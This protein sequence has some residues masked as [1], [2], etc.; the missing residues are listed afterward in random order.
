MKCSGLYTALVTPFKAGKLDEA[1]LKK[2]IARQIE[3]GVNKMVLLG[4]TGE[5]PTLSYE[6]KKSIL[7][8]GRQEIGLGTMIV[9]VGTPSTTT[10]IELAKIAEDFG[11]D[12]L[13]GVTPYYNKPNQEGI[14]RHFEEVS[15]H[16]SLP[17]I[18]YSVKGRTGV[19]IDVSTV[20]RLSE[21]P[22]IVG[23]KE[24]SCDLSQITDIIREMRELRKDFAILSGD[25]YLTFPIM[26]L[27]GHGLIGS[28]VSNVF[29][30]KMKELVTSLLEQNF[31]KARELHFELLPLFST[32]FAETNPICIKA[33][34]SQLGLPSGDPRLPLTPLSLEKQKE[35]VPLLRNYSEI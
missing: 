9:G 30:K 8:I 13:L 28:A 32:L 33:A 4:S 10:T 29:P 24:S 25:E 34:L 26:A 12:A 6:E 19:N 22:N 21:I 16:T 14:F 27:G 17:L 15:K 1:G 31:I 18:V 23:I 7:S 2:L 35:L 3:Q 11:A 5:A 20:K